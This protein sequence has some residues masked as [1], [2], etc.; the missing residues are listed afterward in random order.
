MDEQGLIKHIYDSQVKLGLAC[1]R[2]KGE[3]IPITS[4]DSITFFCEDAHETSVEQLIGDQSKDAGATLHTLI[5]SWHK[6]AIALELLAQEARTQGR[7]KAVDI[8][9]RHISTLE[10][11]IEIL[12]NTLDKK[13]TD[14]D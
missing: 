7:A 9:K 5:A 2:C 8:L 6:N 14:K 13:P 10:A 12:K 4:G 3:L 11:R 1:S